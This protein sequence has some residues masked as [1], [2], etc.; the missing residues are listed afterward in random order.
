MEK[1]FMITDDLMEKAKSYM[2][3]SEKRDLSRQIADL[4]LIPMKTAEQ[5]RAGEKLLAMPN[6]RAEDMAT[7][8]I[9]LLRTLLG[10]YFDIEV[11]SKADAYEQYDFYAGEH[12]YN[13]LERYKS[14]AWKNKAF[15]ILSDFK[16]FRKFV[17]TEIFNIRA[18]WNDPVARFTAAVQILSTPENIKE[19][20]GELQRTSDEYTEALRKQKKMMG[21][22]KND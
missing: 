11:D 15:D 13:Q 1:H 20:L 16:E 4:C 21:D 22:G 18:N 9:L 2:P 10:F 8:Q 7:K 17:D 3:I 14:T 12:I 19:L 6:M 5:N